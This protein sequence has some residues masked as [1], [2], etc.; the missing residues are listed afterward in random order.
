[1]MTQ[2][3]LTHIYRALKV[4]KEIIEESPELINEDEDELFLTAWIIV[5]DKLVENYK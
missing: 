1:M 4:M 3:D 2:A 5:N